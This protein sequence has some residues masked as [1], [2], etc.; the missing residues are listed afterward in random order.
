MCPSRH[1]PENHS[2]ATM[3][4]RPGIR[5]IER[6]SSLLLNE[7]PASLDVF[8]RGGTFAPARVDPEGPFV[9]V[10]W[11]SWWQTHRHAVL[12]V[13]HCYHLANVATHQFIVHQVIVAEEDLAD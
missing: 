2:K 6:E 11:N 9:G 13:F 10:K 7:S 8:D 1:F 4:P 12:L 3:C 5:T